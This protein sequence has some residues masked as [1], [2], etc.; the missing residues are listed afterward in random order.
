[1]EIEY[2]VVEKEKKEIYMGGGCYTQCNVNT[3]YGEDTWCCD[4][5]RN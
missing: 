2:D 3:S 1:M 5:I 4:R